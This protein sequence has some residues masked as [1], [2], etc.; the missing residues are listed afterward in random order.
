MTNAQFIRLT[1]KICDAADGLKDSSL[2]MDAKT[3]AVMRLVMA[4]LGGEATLWKQGAI[5][6]LAEEYIGVEKF[7][8]EL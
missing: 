6:R 1:Q 2:K 8:W 5:R 3:S 4:D 7:K